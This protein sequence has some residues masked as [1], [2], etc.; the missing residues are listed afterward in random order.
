MAEEAIVVEQLVVGEDL[1]GDLLGGADEQVAVGGAAG[2]ELRSTHRR[3][4]AL[5][6]DAVHHLRVGAEELVGGA[7]GGVGYVH[8]RVDSHR[9][10]R[11]VGV[12][13]MG[14]LAVQLHQR[15]EAGWGAADD[16]DHQWQPEHAGASHR[17][18]CAADRDP[19][20]QRLL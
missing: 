10:L 11:G 17:R 7:L 2:V 14:G 9:E 5:A 13:A 6:A 19:N 1:L 4:A 20:W 15:R 8:V 12:R 18:G 16:G 3:P